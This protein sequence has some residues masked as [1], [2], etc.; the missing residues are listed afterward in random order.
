M[1]NALITG[2]SGFFG[3]V[4]IDYLL[5]KGW[6]LISGLHTKS[7]RIE[8]INGLNITDIYYFTE[9]GYKRKDDLVLD[10]LTG[11]WIYAEK[12]GKVSFKSN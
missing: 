8:I 9:E 4:L 3:G 12:E 2:G 11:Y 7:S 10:R 5:K 6:N 1:R